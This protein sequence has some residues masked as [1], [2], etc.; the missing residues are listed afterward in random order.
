MSGMHAVFH[1]GPSTQMNWY[2]TSG[3]GGFMPAGTRGDTAMNGGAVMYEAGKIL[4]VGG[5]P[6]FG[7]S[8]PARTTAEVIELK[9]VGVVPT[10]RNITGTLLP[11][12][13]CAFI[14]CSYTYSQD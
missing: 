14:S 12:H 9:S 7:L 3:D 10:V 4:V 13:F 1:A 11:V 6:A 5:G 2:T 8:L